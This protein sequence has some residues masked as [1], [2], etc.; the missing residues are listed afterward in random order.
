MS[1]AATGAGSPAAA[2]SLQGREHARLRA[3]SRELASALADIQEATSREPGSPGAR[4][5]AR[6][7]RGEGRPQD[8][9]LLGVVVPQS[10]LLAVVVPDL[11]SG[12][13]LVDEL[14]AEGRVIG[15]LHS[16]TEVLF[17][18]PDLPSRTGESRS[19]ESAERVAQ[20]VLRLV[21]KAVIGIS[22]P[23]QA[24]YEL[25]TALEEAQQTD[26]FGKAFAFADDHWA[27]I[28]VSRL[29][30]QLG[31]C[32]TVTNP[33][34]RLSQH[35]GMEASVSAWLEHDRNVPAA[36]AALNVHPNTLRYRLSRVRDLTGLDL[37]DPDARLLAQLLLR[38]TRD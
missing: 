17:L 35:D 6:L 7:V 32:L 14:G 38:R 31:R 19:R 21:S 8:E 28:G 5:L 36:A 30:E 9:L 2:S 13:R 24:V 3:L 15:L 37:G 27:Q 11:R 18:V 34:M 22:S 29:A 16:E 25:P 20:Q 4:S 33:L 23:V 10:R 1:T 26:R 12:Q